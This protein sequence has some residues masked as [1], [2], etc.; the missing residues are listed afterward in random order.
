MNSFPFTLPYSGEVKIE[1]GTTIGQ[2]LLNLEWT[3]YA[4]TTGSAV[5]LWIKDEF[6]RTRDISNRSFGWT[7]RCVGE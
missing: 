5:D 1:D 7:V 6:I 3:N 4:N 2:G